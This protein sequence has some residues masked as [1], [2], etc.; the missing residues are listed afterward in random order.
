MSKECDKRV[1]RE[2]TSRQGNEKRRGFVGE[3]RAERPAR[4]RRNPGAVRRLKG[5][6][7]S[8]VV[9]LRKTPTAKAQ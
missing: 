7:L 5:R 2:R 9:A 6:R 3:A 4:G 8:P 1:S